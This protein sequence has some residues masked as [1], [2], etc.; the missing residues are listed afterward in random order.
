[1]DNTFFCTQRGTGD[2][3]KGTL[4]STPSASAIPADS[5]ARSN[6]NSATIPIFRF[7]LLASN[8]FINLRADCIICIGI[9]Q[10]QNADIERVQKNIFD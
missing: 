3:P 5:S 1:L 7:I 2:S 6:A 4:S 8:Q 9:F 10:A